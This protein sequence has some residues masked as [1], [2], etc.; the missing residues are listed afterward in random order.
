MLIELGRKVLPERVRD[1][2]RPKIYFAREMRTQLQDFEDYNPSEYW[3]S[4]YKTADN[5]TDEATITPDEA[6]KLSSTYHYNQVENRIIEGLSGEI[7]DLE[8]CKALDIGSGAGH[9]VNFWHTLGVERAT[10]LEISEVAV[11]KLKDKFEDKQNIE[12]RRG[13]IGS[14]GL[15][16]KNN[17]FELV[18]AIGVL[19]HLV[20]DDR[21]ERAIENIS[22]Y[23]RKGGFVFIGG[24]FGRLSLYSQFHGSDKFRSNNDRLEG[25]SL[26]NKKK[27]SLR[28]WR[29]TL[30]KYGLEVIGVKR[31]KTPKNI[32]TPENN[33]L[34]CRKT[35]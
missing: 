20:D 13:D 14:K 26:T 32:N 21:W 25:D 9:W 16:D 22:S 2:L 4:Y 18:S 29:K 27:R 33:V 35:G 6:E 23:T 7:E 15:G 30:K 34:I 5:L 10:G 24:E 19:F 31:S 8:E 1:Y 28:V 3:E 17:S 11:E 12:I